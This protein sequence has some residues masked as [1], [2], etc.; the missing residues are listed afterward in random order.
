MAGGLPLDA[1]LPNIKWELALGRAAADLD[2]DTFQGHQSVFDQVSPT[3]LDNAAM[4][5]PSFVSALGLGLLALGVAAV[6][7]GVVGTGSQSLVPGDWSKKSCPGGQHYDGWR[8]GCS[9]PKGCEFRHG[10]CVGFPKK[11][12][13][14]SHGG[15][16][17]CYCGKSTANYRDYKDDDDFCDEPD[18]Q[19]FCCRKDEF[20]R[21]IKDY[22]PPRP[23]C[24][25][26]Q[27]WSWQHRRCVCPGGM[28]SLLFGFVLKAW[29]ADGGW[30]SISR[31]SRGTR[32][33]TPPCRPRGVGVRKNASVP[34]IPTT[35]SPTV[36]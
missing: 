24:P 25:G 19:V 21:K 17:Q 11:A 2:A 16:E 34:R 31:F 7:G 6:P 12:K 4:H 1:A 18:T 27:V 26:K 15:G 8:G 14:S 32:A 33:S 22:C 30:L 23:T 13:P 36:S 35:M 9:C 10:R 20:P 5:L 29:W 28:V 3:R